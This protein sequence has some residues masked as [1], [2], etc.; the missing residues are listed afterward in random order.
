MM[1]PATAGE[2]TDETPTSEGEETPASEG[3]ETVDR[4]TDGTATQT[5]QSH[6]STGRYDSL[7]FTL[8]M[9]PASSTAVQRR[10]ERIRGR[11]K[12]LHGNGMLE[13]LT[14]KRWNKE[15]NIDADGTATDETAASLFTEFHERADAVDA[16]LEPFFQEH[17]AVNNFFSTSPSDRSLV[18]PVLCVTVRRD[19]ELVGLYPC[20]RHSV[21]H[22]VGDCLDMLEDGETVTNM[23]PEYEAE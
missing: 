17:E 8:Y 1:E 21:H 23:R 19:E 12:E 18:F 15:V 4:E 10:Q 6:G 3:D 13:T 7:S 16:R 9:R 2:S 22:S 20:W 5:D 14:V 11:F